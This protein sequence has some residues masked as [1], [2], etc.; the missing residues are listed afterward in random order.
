VKKR[1][2]ATAAAAKTATAAARSACRLPSF[3]ISEKA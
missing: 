2:A 1:P 3:H